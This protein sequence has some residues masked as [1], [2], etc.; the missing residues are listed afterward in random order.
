MEFSDDIS[1]LFDYNHW[2]QLIVTILQ[3]DEISIPEDM[4][5]Y[6]EYDVYKQITG[7]DHYKDPRLKKK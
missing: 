6:L 1:F 7:E 3:D 2:I 4:M 5:K